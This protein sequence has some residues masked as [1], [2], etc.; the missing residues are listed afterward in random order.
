MTD[1]TE[2]ATTP[3]CTKSKNWDSSVQIQSG[4]SFSLEFVTQDPGES[5]FLDFGGVVFSLEIVIRV[6]L[7][8]THIQISYTHMSP[9]PYYTTL[10]DISI[11][12]IIKDL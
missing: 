3:N 2:N 5:E 4:P 6:S 7:T 11:L 10:S 8:H 1:S 9:R 12:F